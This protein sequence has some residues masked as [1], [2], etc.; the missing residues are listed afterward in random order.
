MKYLVITKIATTKPLYF[1][2]LVIAE[3]YDEIEKRLKAN[4][5][6]NRNEKIEKI[7]PIDNSCEN[8]VN[9]IGSIK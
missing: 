3:N 4:R 5:I 7:Y 2:Y 1:I 8:I 6:F 9:F